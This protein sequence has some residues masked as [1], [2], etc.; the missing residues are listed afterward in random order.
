MSH[1]QL[2]ID[3]SHVLSRDLDTN[4]LPQ[5][6]IGMCNQLSSIEKKMSSQLDTQNKRWSKIENQSERQNL[7]MSNIESQVSHI[8]A[9]QQKVSEHDRN[10]TFLKPDYLCTKDQVKEHDKSLQHQ[11]QFCDDLIEKNTEPTEKVNDLR[12]K[13][14]YLIK[15]QAEINIKQTS[16]EEKLTNIQWRSMRENIIFSGLAEATDTRNKI[17]RVRSRISSEQNFILKKI[18][19]LIV[20]IGSVVIKHR[21]GTTARS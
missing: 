11:S 4:G 14:E 2:D 9:L 8:G 12:D 6:A 16:T 13:Y 3:S 20:I 1:S 10:L 19:S 17:V 5:W 7:R 18:Y 21:N 15:R